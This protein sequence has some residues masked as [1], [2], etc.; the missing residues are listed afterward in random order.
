M[1]IQILEK[2]YIEK[3]AKKNKKI[4]VFKKNKLQ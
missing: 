4:L 1:G 2:K 3:K